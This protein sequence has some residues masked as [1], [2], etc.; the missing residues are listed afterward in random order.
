MAAAFRRRIFAITIHPPPPSHPTHRSIFS[1]HLDID[2]VPV[3]VGK[4]PTPDRWR[5][6]QVALKTVPLYASWPYLRAVSSARLPSVLAECSHWLR[7]LARGGG[8]TVQTDDVI[9]EGFLDRL[10]GAPLAETRIALGEGDGPCGA[11]LSAA[12]P[13]RG[14]YINGAYFSAKL[15]DALVDPMGTLKS[16]LGAH[17]PGV[18]NLTGA[19]PGSQRRL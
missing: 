1:L 6:A 19:V 18:E 9:G 15:D 3:V 12:L 13:P 11:I 5:Q 10:A 7:C 2:V 14:V 16:L 8:A 17:W 4:T